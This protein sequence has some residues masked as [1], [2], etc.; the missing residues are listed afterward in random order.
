MSCFLTICIFVKSTEF[1]HSPSQAVSNGQR[2]LYDNSYDTKERSLVQILSTGLFE[3]NLHVLL[4]LYE[5]TL[6]SCS[7]TSR[8]IVGDTLPKCV[9]EGCSV[10]DW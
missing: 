4:C 7:C 6:V 5:F 1:P 9:S 8:L 10:M 2:P 3:S